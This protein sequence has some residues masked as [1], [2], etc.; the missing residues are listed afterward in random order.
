MPSLNRLSI[1]GSK[2]IDAGELARVVRKCPL[3]KFVQL[4]QVSGAQVLPLLVVFKHS[5]LKDWLTG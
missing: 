1:E 5:K 4:P 2:G 3:L